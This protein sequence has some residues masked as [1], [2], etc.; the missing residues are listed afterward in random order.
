MTLGEAIVEAMNAGGA[1]IVDEYGR[2]FPV[3]SSG[4]CSFPSSVGDD[5]AFQGAEWEL[6]LGDVTLAKDIPI[7]SNFVGFL[8]DSNEKHLFYKTACILDLTAGG[9]YPCKDIE[10]REHKQVILDA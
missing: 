10:I 5:S 7:D 6:S 4:I 2:V 9:Y 1:T 8:G 3:S